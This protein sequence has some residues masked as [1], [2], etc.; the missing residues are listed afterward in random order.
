MIIAVNVT[1]TTTTTTVTI[2][3]LCTQRDVVDAKQSVISLRYMGHPFSPQNCPS[4]GGSGPLSN[5]WFP[6]SIRVLNLNGISI[7]SAVFAGLTSVTD[8][9]T[10]RLTD[11]ATGSVTIGCIYA[12]STGDVVW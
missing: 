11:H 8:R 2:A 7:G 5:T 3:L 9:P 1:N 4:H 10:D 6:G 12:H